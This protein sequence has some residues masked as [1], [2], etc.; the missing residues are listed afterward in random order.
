MSFSKTINLKSFT[1]VCFFQ[2]ARETILSLINIHEKIMHSR[3]CLSHIQKL[4][5]LRNLKNK[6]L[7]NLKN[8]K[9]KICP[10]FLFFAL[11]FIFW[12]CISK[13]LHCSQ[14]IR[15]EKFVSCILLV[16]KHCFLA[17]SP[18]GESRQTRKHCVPIAQPQLKQILLWQQCTQKQSK[19]N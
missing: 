3:A 8:K 2:I 19:T 9:L 12:H 17:M 6:K 7:R 4:R 11:Y 10:A 14:L 15:I 18:E 5:K 1:S 16:Q 13:T